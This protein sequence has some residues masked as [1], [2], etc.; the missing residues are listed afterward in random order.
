MANKPYLL[1]TSATLRKFGILDYDGYDFSMGRRNRR[2]YTPETMKKLVRHFLYDV[3][4]PNALIAK[5]VLDFPTEDSRKEFRKEILKALAYAMTNGRP[6]V[7]AETFKMFIDREGKQWYFE[8]VSKPLL[9]YVFDIPYG[10]NRQKFAGERMPKERRWNLRGFLTKRKDTS[11]LRPY[12]HT[13]T[14]ALNELINAYSKDRSVADL[15]TSEFM[16]RF[17]CSKR[18]VT[19]F[20]T[21][22]RERKQE[23]KDG[24]FLVTPRPQ[25]RIEDAGT[26]EKPADTAA[27]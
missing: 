25:R 12:G 20:R 24:S 8:T 15:T 7:D 18:T 4:V 10:K 11:K 6:R 26:E 2:K 9:F 23:G 5:R 13:A 27:G 21:Y 19:K 16:E 14:P 3:I 1:S 22:I 17:K